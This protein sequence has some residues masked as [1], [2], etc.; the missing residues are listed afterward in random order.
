[1]MAVSHPLDG[2]VY[3]NGI[4]RSMISKS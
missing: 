3:E 1:V 4:D 2:L